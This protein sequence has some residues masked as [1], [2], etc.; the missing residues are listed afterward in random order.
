M[1]NPTDIFQFIKG[2]FF[3]IRPISREHKGYLMTD[4]TAIIYLIDFEI[5][6]GARDEV[7]EPLGD[8]R[9]LAVWHQAVVDQVFHEAIPGAEVFKF[10]FFVSC[11]F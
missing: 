8:D 2:V 3:P 7:V 5:E 6:E 4:V 9:I 10:F 11:F 1:K